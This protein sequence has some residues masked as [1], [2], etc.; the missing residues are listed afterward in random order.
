MG[1][2]HQTTARGGAPWA[3]TSSVG[4]DA[5]RNDPSEADAAGQGHD[6][7]LQIAMAG[8]AE[9][10]QQEGLEEASSFLRAVLHQLVGM[11]NSAA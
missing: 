8:L 4:D 5:K 10:C 3:R 6:L 7:S 9:H 1:N 2:S 11:Q